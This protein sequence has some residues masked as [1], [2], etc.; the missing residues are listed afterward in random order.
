MHWE[1]FPLVPSE[2]VIDMGRMTYM[3]N[4]GKE[5]W[6]PC[7]F[8][9]LKGVGE[10]VVMIDTSAS[11]QVMSN[12]RTE[13]V[14]D[15]M[16]FETALEGVGLKPVEISLVILTHLMY[17]HCAN[18]KF[19]PNARFV[20][21]KSELEYARNPHPL[22]AGTYHS[23]MFEGLDFDLVEGDH[24]LLSGIN[25]IHTPG[26]S[27]GCQSVAV[28]TS[29]GTAVIAGF[30]CIMENFKPKSSGAWIS[31]QQPEVIPPGIHLDMQE[32]YASVK[33]VKDS[34]DIIIPMHDPMLKRITK[35]PEQ[36]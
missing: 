13:P 34:A 17:D 16:S 32:A 33:R 9:I 22:F 23:Q 14:R 30:C 3:R 10:Q 26:H 4:Y 20:V 24:K 12:L 5:P 19:L 2:L 15:L 31:K 35:I 29:A 25:L 6:L 21:Q 28:E 36:M 18:A 11:A 1:I 8:F 7:P 27:P